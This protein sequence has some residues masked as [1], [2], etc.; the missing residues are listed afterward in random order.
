MRY[1]QPDGSF[2]EVTLTGKTVHARWGKGAAVKTRTAPFK[3]VAEAKAELTTVIRKVKALGYLPQEKPK[4]IADALRADPHDDSPLIVY[5]DELLSQGDLR[6]EL[7]ALVSR[8]RKK[9][10]VP[11]LLANAAALFETAENDVHEGFA[12]DLLWAPGFI[13][14]VTLSTEAT[15]DEDELVALTK[16]FLR[17]PV[18]EFIRELNFG[19]SYGSWAACTE[20]VARG[21]HPELVT[22]LRFDAFDSSRVVIEDIDA[23]DFGEVWSRFPELRELKVHAGSIDPGELVLPELRHFSR[24]GGGFSATEL[25]AIT[26]AHWPRLDSLELGFDAERDADLGGLFRWLFQKPQPVTMLALRG[27]MLSVDHVELLLDS[28]LLPKLTVLDLADVMLDEDAAEMLRDSAEKLA[29]LERLSSPSLMS[30]E[31]DPTMPV[32]EDLENLVDHAYYPE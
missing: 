21:R 28:V 24:L 25:R 5:A 2:W 20:Q 16:R 30:E 6:G 27:L 26:R 3:T 18:A 1:L 29:H 32:L 4:G 31:G 13:R 19:L 7:A 15:S 14:E 9:E 17:A 11:F 10:L 23:G 22:A 12:D 8:G